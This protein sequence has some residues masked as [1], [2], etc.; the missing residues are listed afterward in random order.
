MTLREYESTRVQLRW[1]LLPQKK[2]TIQRNYFHTLCESQPGILK[3]LK[4][5]DKG[6][7][8]KTNCSIPVCAQSRGVAVV[9]AS[10]VKQCQGQRD[11]SPQLNTY[12]TAA[13]TSSAP[14]A[15]PPEAGLLAQ[16]VR[17]PTGRACPSTSGMQW[18]LLRGGC[19]RSRL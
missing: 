12:V 15:D 7:P 13:R 8:V 2:V 3:V 19:P 18:P 10:T 6:R 5:D 14:Q 16:A 17:S 4:I 1:K 9:I 11:A